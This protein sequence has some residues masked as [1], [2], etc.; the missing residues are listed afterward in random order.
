MAADGDPAN[1]GEKCAESAGSLASTFQSAKAARSSNLSLHL[2]AQ[3]GSFTNIEAGEPMC[4]DLYS[5][6]SPYP[7]LPFWF[8]QVVQPK[9]GTMTAPSPETPT[10]LS[11]KLRQAHPQNPLRW[12][13]RKPRR[14]PPNQSLSRTMTAPSLAIAF[15]RNAEQ[16][17]PLHPPSPPSL[18]PPQDPRQF[19]PPMPDLKVPRRS[20]RTVLTATPHIIRVPAR[21][22]VGLP[23]FTEFNDFP[24]GKLI[25]LRCPLNLSH[26]G[27]GPGGN[28][29]LR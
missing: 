17:R 7:P 20:A 18:W 5:S 11:A 23:N 28:T 22:M 21:V 29:G 6:L 2:I 10:R 25:G 16:L 26:A 27:R 12:Q 15:G 3:E 14:S 19:Q 24:L 9:L 13:C 1:V 4:V 8:S